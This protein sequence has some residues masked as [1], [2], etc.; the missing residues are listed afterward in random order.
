MTDTKNKNINN[1]ECLYCDNTKK[2]YISIHN[3]NESF[4]NPSICISCRFCCKEQNE[5]EQNIIED[6]FISRDFM[7]MDD[8]LRTK[9]IK[10]IEIQKKYDRSV[11]KFNQ[12]KDKLERKIKK[13]VIDDN[14]IKSCQKI[15]KTKKLYDSLER[16]MIKY[17]EKII[18]YKE[19]I[20]KLRT[21][22]NYKF[23]IK[24]NITI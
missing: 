13:F 9:N 17:E 23:N 8:K 7:T 11:I 22:L 18:S 10:N 3:D 14:I 6:I 2:N 21:M 24:L 4:Y 19:Q 15:T 1:Y 5:I 12:I 16:D 20:D